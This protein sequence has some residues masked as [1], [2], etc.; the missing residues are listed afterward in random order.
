MGDM[1]DWDFEQGFDELQAHQ[2]GE[3][4]AW[5]HYCHQ[6]APPKRKRKSKLKVRRGD[7]PKGEG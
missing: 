1:A 4:D 6:P 7:H 3:C 5:C 2:L